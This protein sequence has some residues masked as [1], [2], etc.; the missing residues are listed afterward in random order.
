MAHISKL[1]SAML[2]N[3]AA[4]MGY[5]SAYI[6]VVTPFLTIAYSLINAYAFTAPYSGIYGWSKTPKRYI[7]LVL[8]TANSH[9]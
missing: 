2:C 7:G 9:N 6:S 8:W 4:A 3:T 5:S 1:W